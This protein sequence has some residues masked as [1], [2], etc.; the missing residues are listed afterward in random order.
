MVFHQQWDQTL[1]TTLIPS[2][3]ALNCRIAECRRVLLRDCRLRLPRGA[4]RQ[5]KFL[6]KIRSLTCLARSSV[7]HL[8]VTFFGGIGDTKEEQPTVPKG[9]L[10]ARGAHYPGFA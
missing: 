4:F 1:F 9:C 10:L 8:Q 2:S 3:P 7:D 5:K 6:G